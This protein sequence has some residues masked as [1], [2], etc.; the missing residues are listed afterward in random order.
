MKKSIVILYILVLVLGGFVYRLLLESFMLGGTPAIVNRSDTINTLRLE[1]NDVVELLTSST[2]S[3]STLSGLSSSTG[4]LIVGS[5]SLWTVKTVGSNGTYLAASSTAAGG[6]SWES[7]P[8]LGTSTAHFW[9]AL[10]TFSS[11]ISVLSAL[12]IPTGTA[13]TV[14]ATGE[15]ALD[16]S[17]NQL[18]VFGSSTANVIQ[19]G[20]EWAKG[21]LVNPTTT[22]HY[23]VLT[24]LPYDISLSKIYC[25][26]NDVS[27]ALTLSFWWRANPTAATTSVA[28]NLT[29]TPTGTSTVTFTAG[30]VS[31]TQSVGFSMVSASG[32]PLSIPV[33]IQYTIIR[34]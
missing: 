17:Q 27:T 9:G 20:P 18:L 19:L 1:F 25:G 29:C 3:L 32:T 6:V 5:S 15:I 21:T 33:S 2:S 28:S 10:Q 13:P 34:K 26:V 11:G 8:V 4:N 30:I 22:R 14:D 23:T 24:D 12:N 7:V 31:S 16:T